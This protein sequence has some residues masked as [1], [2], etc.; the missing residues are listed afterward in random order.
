M[1]ESGVFQGLIARMQVLGTWPPQE[2]PGSHVWVEG[3]PWVSRW[4]FQT[5]F[6]FTP[7][8]GDD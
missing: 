6:I 7:T 4:W 2:V 3:I 1:L 5:F 8:W